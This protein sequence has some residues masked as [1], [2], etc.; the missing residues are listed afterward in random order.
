MDSSFEYNNQKNL[1]PCFSYT[2][3]SIH[4]QDY[5]ELPDMNF[6]VYYI[7]KGSFLD[8]PT[9]LKQLYGSNNQAVNSMGSAIVENGVPRTDYHQGE[10]GLIK[11]FRIFLNGQLLVNQIDFQVGEASS[12]GYFQNGVTWHRFKFKLK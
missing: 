7:M 3:S 4:I 6:L 12:Q 5:S 10:L 8:S 1:I 9:I 11:K 2:I